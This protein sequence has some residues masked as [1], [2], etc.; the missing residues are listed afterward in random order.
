MGARSVRR[1]AELITRR[2]APGPL[3]QHVARPVGSLPAR[4][5]G[6]AISV[7]YE[8]RPLDELH[9][10]DVP[11]AVG[12]HLGR[13]NPHDELRARVIRGERVLLLDVGGAIEPQS[14]GPCGN[15]VDEQHPDVRVRE[16]VSHRQVHPI[17]VVVRKR[18][19][20]FVEHSHETRIAA[21]VRALGVS[22]RV[23]R[24]EEEHVHALDEGAILGVDHRARKKLLVQAVGEAARVEA[25]L[26]LART[27]VVAHSIASSSRPSTSSRL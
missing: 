21:L 20:A 3:R 15:E 11:R 24:G 10:V 22:V 5:G 13:P 2:C 23:G 6:F 14:G 18:D 4:Y 17:A 12:K 8:A 26:Q 16:Q 1:R 25:V 7:R 19:R 27:V 9:P